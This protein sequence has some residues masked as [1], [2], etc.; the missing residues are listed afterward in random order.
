LAREFIAEFGPAI[1][2]F[3]DQQRSRLAGKRR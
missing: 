3:A 2:G 1:A